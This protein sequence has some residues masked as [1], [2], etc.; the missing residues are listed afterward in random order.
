MRTFDVVAQL[1]LHSKVEA[2]PHQV[3][4]PGQIREMQR[5]VAGELQC[6]QIGKEFE[7]VYFLC[8][9]CVFRFSL[10]LRT[11][12]A[13]AALRALLGSEINVPE[14]ERMGLD[15]TAWKIDEQGKPLSILGAD[16]RPL[17]G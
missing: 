2:L 11:P 8:D 7:T 4:S 5:G 6:L 17:G 10:D 15:V 13:R 16:G 9:N 12:H 1:F 14:G 3:I